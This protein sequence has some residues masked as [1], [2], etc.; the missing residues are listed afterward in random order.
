M[1]CGRSYAANWEEELCETY[2]VEETEKGPCHERG[3]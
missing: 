3:E 1:H 2:K